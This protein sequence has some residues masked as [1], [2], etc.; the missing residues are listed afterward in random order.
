MYAESIP[1]RILNL[2]GRLLSRVFDAGS[3]LPGGMWSTIALLIA[4]GLV[5]VGVILW[6]RP[7]RPGRGSTG[8][9]LAGPLLSSG[10][11]RRLADRHAAEG[12][13]S[14]AIIDRVRAVAAGLEERRL[15][16]AQPGRT[17]DE[18]AAQAGLAMPELAADLATAASLFDDVRY[19]GR[20]G[21]RSGYEQVCQLDT[22]LQGRRVGSVD[23]PLPVATAPGGQ[24]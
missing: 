22:L 16:A 5:I 19:G 23:V 24:R 18:L 10:D 14:A 1:T 12:D 21:S 3:A 20:D 2:L 7:A 11:H 13:Y 6:I 8:A 17:A 9:V 15:L 4:L